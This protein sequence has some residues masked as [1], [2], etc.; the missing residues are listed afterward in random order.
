MK[1]RLFIKLATGSA[2]L[3]TLKNKVKA[4]IR[5]IT[6]K[7]RANGLEESTPLQLGSIQFSLD[8]N[9][10]SLFIRWDEKN[11]IELPEWKRESATNI[12]SNPVAYTLFGDTS[13]KIVKAKFSFVNNTED[14]FFRIRAVYKD[15]PQKVA[16]SEYNSLGPPF[17]IS[18]QNELQTYKWQEIP[19]SLKT[20]N[21]SQVCLLWQYAEDKFDPAIP[22][23]WKDITCSSHKIFT[24]LNELSE[25]P[26]S[27]S[28]N[29]V[30]NPW[31][32][33]LEL[34]CLW[35]KGTSTKHTAAEL[36]TKQ[37]YSMGRNDNSFRPGRKIFKY[38]AGED[39]LHL[40]T[41]DSEKI[42]AP[43]FNLTSFLS[44]LNNK[45][46]EEMGGACESWAA[47]VVTFSNIL[48]CGL[49]IK[50][51]AA[52]EGGFTLN[53]SLLI[54]SDDNDWR[55]RDTQQTKE[56]DFAYHVVAALPNDDSSKMLIYDACLAVD[57]RE[58]PSA[59]H[60]P[61]VPAG[62][63]FGKPD[64]VKS[65]LYYL[66]DSE[67][68]D[69]RNFFVYEFNVYPGFIPIIRLKLEDFT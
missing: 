67:E 44:Q 50:R 37:I 14:R 51:F 11:P 35:A 30:T 43:Y 21:I 1:R 56:S 59:P 3:F 4:F 49:R 39:Y 23:E 25:F 20:V 7:L 19:D 8:N 15:A 53:S 29:N 68:R 12:K 66:V 9:N 62:M 38:K 28:K 41:F 55:S 16:L 2:V 69:S 36:I 10:G 63:I 48:R 33:V 64:E 31:V 13:G 40:L 22:L 27:D 17:G 6:S 42:Q 5:P 61:V 52:I 26:W 18:Q 24:V 34:S 46:R 65:Y 45:S 58:N 54:G 47:I 57:E 32:S 60:T